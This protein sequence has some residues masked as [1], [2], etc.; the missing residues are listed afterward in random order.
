MTADDFGELD[1][2]GF[3]RDTALFR[4]MPES[5]IQTIVTEG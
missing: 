5:V 4:D 1:D 3:L 2:I